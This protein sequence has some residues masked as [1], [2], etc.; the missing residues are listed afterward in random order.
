MQGWSRSKTTLGILTGVAAGVALLACKGGTRLFLKYYNSSS[1]PLWNMSIRIASNETQCVSLV[2]ELRRD[3]K[4]YKVLGFDC[5]WVQVDKNNRNKVALLQLATKEGRCGLF[6]LQ[7]YS[8]I[9]D[10]LCDLLTDSSILKV[11]VGAGHDAR[12]LSKDYGIKVSGTCDIRHLVD[13]DDLSQ[14]KKG[15]AGLAAVVLAELGVQLPKDFAVR[16]SNWELRDLSEEQQEYAALDALASVLAFQKLIEKTVKVPF[17]CSERDQWE[18]IYA[19]CKDLIDTEF[20]HRAGLQ[21]LLSPAQGPS[22]ALQRDKSGQ[23]NGCN[24]DLE[25]KRSYRAFS[26]RK[27]PLYENAFLLAPDGAVLCTCDFK[28]AEWYVSKGL[29]T[30]V[31][32]QPFRVQLTFE[33]SGRV[34]GSSGEYYT[35]EKQNQ[36]VVCGRKDGY[37]RKKIVPHEYRKFFPDCFKKHNSHDVLLLCVP[38]H[39]H[40]NMSDFRL[41]RQLSEL[42]NAPISSEKAQVFEDNRSKALRSAARA[43]LNSSNKLPEE[44]AAELKKF[45]QENCGSTV[46]HSLLESLKDIDVQ[47][48]KEGYA[49]HGLL[50]VHHF[51]RDGISG[52]VK[53]EK[54][55]REHFIIEMDPKFLPP[56][57]SVDHCHKNKTEYYLDADFLKRLEKVQVPQR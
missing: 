49:P 33:P 24:P 20:K 25:N 7:F 12:L 14:G 21:P 55:W 6:Q 19:H 56:L 4:H 53:L 41:R 44:R 18:K 30:V 26:E 31:E 37:V 35:L 32:R 17:F 45:I 22:Q 51:A 23:P 46:T 13:P 50:V 40:S 34:E 3:L 28:K 27:S 2:N 47:I 36:C 15:G 1:K 57:W 38:C 5:E 8:S 48:P 29:A 16:V 54:M 10:P 52:I 11:G 42:C 9:P 39:I 43:L